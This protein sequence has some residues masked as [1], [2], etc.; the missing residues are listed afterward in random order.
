MNY[1]P[2]K[3]PY[4]WEIFYIPRKIPFSSGKFQINQRE[5]NFPNFLGIMKKLPKTV[6]TVLSI[7]LT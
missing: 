2:K 5:G 1:F 4:F 3:F 6:V 7:I